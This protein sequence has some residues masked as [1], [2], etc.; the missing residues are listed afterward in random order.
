MN[1]IKYAWENLG[2]RADKIEERI[3]YVEDRNL[4][5]IQIRREN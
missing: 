1:E 4:E 5:M 3:S 2:N